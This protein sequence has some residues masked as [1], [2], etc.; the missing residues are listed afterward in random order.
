MPPDPLALDFLRGMADKPRAHI[1]GPLAAREYLETIS[2]AGRSLLPSVFACDDHE[3][4]GPAGP[5]T[6]RIIRPTADSD[7]PVL[8]WFHG[9][10]FVAGSHRTHDAVLRPVANAVPCIAVIPD[11]RLAPEHPFPAAFDDCWSVLEWVTRRARDF[12]GDPA[13]IAVGGDSA[14]GNLAAA[15]AIAAPDAGIDLR[16]Q[17]LVYPVLDDDFERPSMIENATGYGLETEAMRYYIDAYL[18]DPESRSD[19]RALPMKSRHLRGVAPA[20]VMTAEYDPLR[21]EGEAYA[22]RLQENGV[23]VF[24]RRYLG[25]M[26]GFFGIWG[27]V[28]AARPSFDDAVASLRRAFAVTH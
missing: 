12:G 19:W 7:L 20:A 24:A 17:L 28:P 16:L 4:A 25:L 10:G 26:H 22:V 8:V 23:K 11:Y 2:D 14:G 3:I 27:L 21:D 6:T 15:V 1:E 5:I 18:P 9:G 13:R